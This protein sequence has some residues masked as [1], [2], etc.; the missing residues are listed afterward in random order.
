MVKDLI[1][2]RYDIIIR[3][4][5]P[6]NFS[7]HP[8]ILVYIYIYIYIYKENVNDEKGSKKKEDIKKPKEDTS[9]DLGKLI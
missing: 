2:S 8:H 9:T 7:V 1:V 6:L 5:Q 3:I 4:I